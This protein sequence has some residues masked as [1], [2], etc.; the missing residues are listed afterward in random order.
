LTSFSGGVGYWI[1]VDEALSFSYDLDEGFGRKDIE[2]YSQVL[3]KGYENIVRQSSKQ[4]FYF[5]DHIELLNGNIENG[6]WIMTYNGEVLTGIRQWDGNMI[7][8]PAMGYSDYDVK[9]NGYFN[10]GDI[11]TFKLLKNSTGE[12]IEL[13]GVVPEW[14]S[15][16]IVFIDGLTELE[17][18][19]E[20]FGIDEAYPNPF[21]PVTTL[22]FKLPMDAQVLMQVYNLQGRLVET[23]VDHDMNAG[24]HA[25][26]WNADAQSSGMYFVKMISGDQISTYK[27]LLV[28]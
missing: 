25:V 20:T 23:L 22:S 7:D 21:N 26:V 2:V 8:I 5:V 10:D 4:A 24:Y 17:S 1:I 6:D 11:P 15:N 9:T 12:L 28:K 19:P 13:G 27:L 16:S 3:P 18:I 14:S